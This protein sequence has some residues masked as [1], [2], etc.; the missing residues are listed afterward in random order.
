MSKHRLIPVLV[1]LTV[2]PLLLVDLDDAFGAVIPPYSYSNPGLSPSTGL[3]TDIHSNGIPLVKHSN[4]SATITPVTSYDH[5]RIDP[6]Y[7]PEGDITIDKGTMILSN[8]KLTSIGCTVQFGVNNVGANPSN[9][10]H[11]YAKLP[12]NVNGSIYTNLPESDV[13]VI[14]VDFKD[15]S[16]GCDVSALTTANSNNEPLLTDKSMR[17]TIYGQAGKKA[18]F[19]SHFENITKAQLIPECTSANFDNSTKQL[20]GQTRMCSGTYKNDLVIITTQIGEYG[21][22]STPPGTL[23]IP[24]IFDEKDYTGLSVKSTTEYDGTL[25][26]EGDTIRMTDFTDEDTDATADLYLERDTTTLPL[27]LFAGTGEYSCDMDFERVKDFAKNMRPKFTVPDNITPT[28]K[29]ELFAYGLGFDKKCKPNPGKVSNQTL[30]TDTEM[31]VTIYDKVYKKPFYF[32]PPD[33]IST[34]QPIPVCTTDMIDTSNNNTLKDHNTICYGVH[35]DDIVIITKRL[36]GFYGVAD[37]ITTPTNPVDLNAAPPSTEPASTYAMA[38]TILPLT[39]AEDDAYA[40]ASFQTDEFNNGK[41]YYG[42][43]DY[44]YSD[45]STKPTADIALTQDTIT[46]VHPLFNGT[47]TYNC[48]TNFEHVATLNIDKVPSFAIPNNI[49]PKTPLRSVHAYGLDFHSCTPDPEAVSSLPLITTKE[50]RITI[51]GKAEKTPYYFSPRDRIPQA[52]PIPVCTTDMIDTSNNNVL[53]GNNTICYG[54]HGDDMVIITKRLTGF[55][56]AADTVNLPKSPVDLNAPT[57]PRDTNILTLAPPSDF[58]ALNAD[59]RTLAVTSDPTTTPGAYLAG[60]DRERYTGHQNTRI[61]DL[62]IQ[63]DTKILPNEFPEE[64]TCVAQFRIVNLLIADNNYGNLTLKVPDNLIADSGSFGPNFI[65]RDGCNIDLTKNSTKPLITDKEMRFTIYDKTD[66]HPYYFS[67]RE[68][69]TKAQPIPACTTDMIDTTTN[70]LKG[71]NIMCYGKNGDDIVI[72]TKRLTGFYGT[73]GTIIVPTH[74]IDFNKGDEPPPPPSDDDYFALVPTFGRS[75][76]TGEQVVTCGYKMDDTCRDVTAYH[77]QYERDTIQTNTTHTFA[78]KAYAPTLLRNVVLAFSVPNVG[79]PLSTAEAYISVN[80]GINYSE[81]SY[82]YIEGVTVHDPNNILDYDIT[83]TIVSTASCSGGELQCTQV[84][85]P[86]VL[87][88]EVM[89]HEPFA[90]Q[91]TDTLGLNAINY[92][93]E[94]VFVTGTSLNAP[95]TVHTGITLDTGDIRPTN[96]V[97]VRT[98]KVSDLWA[99]AFGNTWS[100][101]SFGNFVIVQ[102]APYAGTFPVCT[103]INDRI[104]TPFKIKLDWHTQKM[105]E[106]RDSLYDAYKTKAYAEIDNIFTYEFGDMDS[107]TRTLINLGWLT[108]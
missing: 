41:I 33:S 20:K 99:D 60:N 52:Q 15:Y 40:Q 101:N 5:Y 65:K 51:Y 73:A 9:A 30:I 44:R 2:V 88:R 22:A 29:N 84:T 82:H 56:G 3:R 78:L 37:T 10:I 94:G 4:N 72:I 87:F 100:R 34:A 21:S 43:V 61:G 93:N 49:V 81:P 98:D 70:T 11:E 67:P 23:S 76:F 64:S 32:S 53:K 48:F 62:H 8:P 18:F 102:Y 107:R 97:L 105:I 92:M 68:N 46:L 71:N 89:N 104:C 86:D 58:P 106:L 57:V 69:I 27:T 31:R 26:Y 35:G 42:G 95:P 54:I 63:N 74:I 1:L 85:I 39:E 55:Y 12:T 90:I 7:Q 17:V 14:G 16:H 103:D 24:P 59:G 75:Q 19:S 36:V 28:Q 79:A 80:L 77:V 45:H 91:V 25:F 13:K 38:L 50:M 6:V 108:E 96:L 47:S 66:E 83:G